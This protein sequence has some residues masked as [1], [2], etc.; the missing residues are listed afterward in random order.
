MTLDKFKH[1]KSWSNGALE[2]IMSDVGLEFKSAECEKK[3]IMNAFSIVNKNYDTR[4]LFVVGAL[5][6]KMLVDD[7]LLVGY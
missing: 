4:G 3:A 7:G 2:M 1:I 6:M 5:I